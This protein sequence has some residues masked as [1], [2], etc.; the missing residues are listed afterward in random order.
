MIE[1]QNSE[2]MNN[3]NYTLVVNVENKSKYKNFNKGIIQ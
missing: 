2:L 3:N 1:I